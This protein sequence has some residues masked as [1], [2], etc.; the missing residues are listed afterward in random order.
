VQTRRHD[1]RSQRSRSS[2]AGA[3]FEQLS[4]GGGQIA[5]APLKARDL[6]FQRSF[7]SRDARERAWTVASFDDR[8]LAVVAAR[9]AV[10]AQRRRH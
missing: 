9:D 4:L 5:E 7:A 3:Q 10:C 8:Q 1:S 2:Q 6:L